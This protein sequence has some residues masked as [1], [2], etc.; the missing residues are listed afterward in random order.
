M[1]KIYFA[2][3]LATTT[4]SGVF[5][6]T[7]VQA[8]CVTV[9]VN[10][11]E[12][13]GDIVGRQ[14]FEDDDLSITVLGGASIDGDSRD[15]IKTEGTGV[16]VENL[17]TLTT[18]DGDG[19][20]LESGTDAANPVVAINRGTI[21]VDSTGSG[22]E[23]KG[24]NVGDF[25]L[26][27]NYG[28]ITATGADSE[29]INGD[30]NVTVILHSGSTIGADDKTI[31]L[32]DNATVTISDGALV[33]SANEA[34]ETGDD[35]LI[36]IGDAD[37]I[38]TDDAF[39][40][41]E[42][43]T[44]TNMGRIRAE[45]G[46]GIDLDS[47][48]ITNGAGAEITSENSSGIDYDASDEEVSTVNNSGL[49]RGVVGIEVE[50]G[51]AEDDAN[52]KSQVVNNFNGGTVQGTGGMAMVLGAGNDT[53]N[54]FGG[55][56]VIGDVML[57]D[58]DDM[59]ALSGFGEDGGLFGLAGN[60]YDGGMGNDMAVINSAFEAIL[61]ATKVDEVFSFTFADGTESWAASFTNFEIYKFFNG[62]DIVSYTGDEIV[63]AMTPVPLPAAV[64]MML[65]ALGGL[66]VA[67]R[68]R[69]T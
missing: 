35:A 4:L 51:S 8:A 18:D 56:T 21:D 1:N 27:E 10:E 58:D 37:I 38:A 59:L 42:R 28:D 68:R 14:K 17:G 57:G 29:G 65:A 5:L 20:Q 63:G 45:D 16:T 62:D 33:T 19:I 64:W 43:L 15:A 47:G 32:K 30:D 25:A 13:S 11:I 46:D 2:S 9:G 67:G 48:T 3:L 24:V 36:M 52:E 34:V 55:S 49:I 40:P 66:G 60:L 61:A 69:T 7:S 22:G 41:S 39:N 23:V 26:V 54:L 50:L 44:L 53:V 12:C 31:D 6:S